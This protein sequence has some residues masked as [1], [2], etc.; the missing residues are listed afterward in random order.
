[1]CL[2]MREYLDRAEYLKKVVEGEIQGGAPTGAGAGGATGQQVKPKG[3]S[4]EVRWAKSMLLPSTQVACR[5]IV[6]L[7][8][9]RVLVS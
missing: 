3:A 7:P 5:V 2:Q 4:A 6:A 9:D 8:L 1:M